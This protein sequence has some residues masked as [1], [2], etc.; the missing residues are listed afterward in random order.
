MEKLKIM[1]YAIILAAGKSERL[2]DEND[3]L[4]V[5]VA[6]HPIVYYSLISFNDHPDIDEIVLVVNKNNEKSLKKLI[7]EYSLKTP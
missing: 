3:K 1:N 5:E 7:K 6:G 4:L 2:K